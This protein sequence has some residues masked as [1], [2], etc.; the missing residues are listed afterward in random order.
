MAVRRVAKVCHLADIAAIPK[1]EFEHV[2]YLHVEVRSLRG[3][4]PLDLKNERT[5]PRVLTIL[6]DHTFHHA[7]TTF[8]PATHH[9]NPHIFCSYLAFFIAELQTIPGQ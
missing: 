5:I 3:E 6:S 2:A 1:R 9:I 8:R 7:L 4:S